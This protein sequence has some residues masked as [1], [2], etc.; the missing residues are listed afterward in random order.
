MSRP[1]TSP[2]RWPTAVEPVKLTMS[3]CGEA[4]SASPASAPLPVTMLTTPGGNPASTTASANAQHGQRVLRRGLDHDRVAHGQRGADLAGHVDQREVV[5][6]DAGDHADR[7]ALGHGAEQAAGRQRPWRAS[8][9]APAAG[10]SARWR[11][12]RSGG[13]GR[14]SGA[15]AWSWPPAAWRRSRPAPAGPGRR[16]GRPGRR[17]AGRAARPAR[18]GVVRH[19]GP[20]ASAAAAARPRDL[21][22]RRLGGL[23]DDLLGGRVDDRRRCPRRRRPGRPPRACCTSSLT[24][25][26]L[27]HV[28]ISGNPEPAA[29]PA[30]MGKPGRPADRHGSAAAG[31]GSWSAAEQPWHPLPGYRRAVWRTA[32]DWNEKPRTSPD[33]TARTRRQRAVAPVRTCDAGR[34]VRGR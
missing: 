15:P 5:G 20:K 32:D 19:H 18:S 17:P 10:R 31:R 3:T 1:A 9:S 33:P 13:S 26:R 6:R 7:L 2:M 16:P 21:V 25:P 23:P 28:L 24:T 22:G 29:G 30:G 8:R 4:T 27:E 34:R 14:R 11:P 12:G